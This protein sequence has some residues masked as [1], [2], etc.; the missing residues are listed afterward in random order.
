MSGRHVVIIDRNGVDRFRLPDGSPAVSPDVHTVSLL[1]GPALVGQAR[2]GECAQIFGYDIDDEAATAAVL[3]TLHG[4]RPI[5]RIVCFPENLQVL[6]AEAREEF[7]LPGMTRAQVVPFR[8]KP[9]MKRTA[10]R[11]GLPVADWCAVDS[12]EQARPLLERY[13]KVVLKPRDGAGSAGVHVVE[14][15][16]GLDSLTADLA[17]YQAEQF[18]DA[19]MIH[20]DAAV[21]N[22]AVE[23][24]RTSRYL[25]TTLSH[26]AGRPLGS[27]ISQDPDLNAAAGVLLDQVTKAFQVKDAV[28]HLEAFVTAGGLVFNEVA[29][30][31]GGGGIVTLVQAATGYNLFEAM[32]RM[33]LGEPPSRGYPVTAPAGGFLLLYADAGVLEAVDDDAVPPEW[34][35]E[36]RTSVPI[37]GRHRPV[38]RAGGSV[39]S[40]VVRADGE[41]Q[42][43]ERLA[44]IEEHV[45]IHM[46]GVQR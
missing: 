37:G 39:V 1:T 3:R 17:H 35:V 13:G 15:P 38:G 44:F 14:S 24:A 22:G 30:R 6:A 8:D 19:P 31:A 18:I 42:A 29:C 16:A 41:R 28:L 34:I 43:V 40:Y 33:A 2:R 12:A 36:R 21:V 26:T 45:R 25:A 32:V 20:V 7:G 9:A 10:E 23:V 5:D 11:A 46:T 4:M 27:V